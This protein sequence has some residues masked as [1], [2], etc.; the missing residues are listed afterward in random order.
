MAVMVFASALEAQYVRC[1]SVDGEYRECYVGSS[2]RIILVRELSD[3]LCIQGVTWGTA[4]E[5]RVWVWRGC[6]A[7]FSVG[8]TDPPAARGDL[9]VCESFGDGRAFCSTRKYSRVRLVRQLSN[10]PCEEGGTWGYDPERGEIWV[11]LG[12]RGEFRVGDDVEQEKE[13]EPLDAIVVCKSEGGKRKAK[14]PADTSAGVQLFRAL[15]D[16]RCRFGD[17]WGWDRK[18]IWVRNGCRAEFAVRGRPRP[19]IE[20]IVCESDGKR[21]RYEADTRYGVAIVRE[22]GEERCILGET[23]GFDDDGIW[24]DRGC[25]AQFALGGYRLPADS[26]PQTAVRVI[27]ESSP[28]TDSFC[29][30]D[31]GRGVGLVRELGESTCVLNRNWAY[32]RNGIRVRDGCS[33]EFAVAR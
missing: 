5:G 30:V 31:T 18:Q 23:W 17:D 8:V 12:C 32:D 26:V 13:P 24:V 16:T 7:N 22:I 9:V 21:T 28:G 10:S 27:C 25:S 20:A 6:R 14:C 15:G 3:L 1:E 33:A 4:S 11:D 19:L 2:G 29:E